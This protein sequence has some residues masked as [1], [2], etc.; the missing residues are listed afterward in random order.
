MTND[1]FGGWIQES[2]GAQSRRIRELTDDLGYLRSSLSRQSA[3]A[4]ALRSDLASL[5]GSIETRLARLTAAFDAFVEL[6]SLRDQLSLVAGPA[7][8]RQA[9]RA[10]LAAL[11]TAP[12]DGGPLLDVSGTPLAPGYWLADALGAL[13]PDDEGAADRAAT[14]DLRRTATF[15]TVAGAACGRTDLVARWASDALG[16]LDP[17]RPVTRAQRAVWVAAAQARLG[18]DARAALLERL[19]AAV[20]A[21]PA[22]TVDEAVAVWTSEVRLSA[23]G[24]G[25]VSRTAEA[26]APQVPQVRHAAAALTTLRTLVDAPVAAPA[27]PVYGT[28]GDALG[29]VA[30]DGTTGSGDPTLDELVAVLRA[31]VDEGA[32]EERALMTRIAELEAVVT[33]QDAPG[34]GWDAPAGDLLTLLRED[35]LTRR[36]ATGAAAR[37]ACAPWLLTVADTFLAESDVAPPEHVEGPVMGVTLRARPTGPVEGLDEALVRART[38]QHP[39]TPRET[40][41]TTGVATAAAVLWLATAVGGSDLRWLFGVL[42]VALTVT[43]GVLVTRRVRR[44][45]EDT[46]RATRGVAFVG[47]EAKRLQDRVTEVTEVV[48]T[49]RQDAREQHA[50]V[51]AG[52]GRPATGTDGTPT[53]LTQGVTGAGTTDASVDA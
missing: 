10:R 22:A 47:R 37:D 23:G 40:R 27:V 32:E 49:C 46:A 5:R 30:D 17:D 4:S 36:D 13:G 48:G 35:A 31:L 26:S 38:P 51:V 12:R 20:G 43:A 28:P 1:L 8:V 9:T 33:G 6:S 14:I 41:T 24:G 52:L 16:T 7:L 15:L 19:R 2:D 53:V 34:P 29:D 45:R 50:R 3:T 42:A 18:D 39:R 21:L 44:S 25:A 11:G